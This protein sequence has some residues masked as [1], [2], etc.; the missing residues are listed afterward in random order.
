[1]QASHRISVLSTAALSACAVMWV[2]TPAQAAPATYAT[3]VLADNPYVYH[4][5]NDTVAND[6]AAA[7]TS[8]NA[9]P[10]IY[11]SGAGGTATSTTGAGAG[12]DAAVSFPGT[13]TGATG[14]YAGNVNIRPF[15][16]SLANASFEAVFK[17]NA[18]FTSTTKQ[19][20]F[21]VFNT[22]ATTAAEI[23][24]N[25]QGNDA[26]GAFA[27]TTRFFIRGDDGDAVGVHFVNAGLYD[28]NYHHLV[29]TFDA[30]QA[31]VGAFTAY[32]DGV[33]QTLTLQQVGTGVADA[34]ADPDTFVNFGFDPTWAAR[35]VRGALG[36]TT[37]GQLANITIDET[38]LYTTTL[39]AEQA[40]VHAAAAGVPEPASLALAGLAGLG[41]LGRRRRA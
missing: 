10:G 32:V 7:D 40:G 5:L 36:A 18:G 29:F 28:G 20:L 41:L 4:R 16:A 8:V 27:N 14:A 25:S 19:S 35:N 23:T 34:D 2:A 17:T 38:A 33:A 22:G 13:G 11:K 6:A 24:L 21:G 3:A 31:G 30:S 26:L 1:M 37:V 15:G 39:S 12:S 9:R